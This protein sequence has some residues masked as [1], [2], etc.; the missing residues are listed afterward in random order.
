MSHLLSR[1]LVGVS[2]IEEN[3]ESRELQSFK[4]LHARETDQPDKVQSA[5]TIAAVLVPVVLVILVI[6]GI[7]IF[8]VIR[9][10]LPSKTPARGHYSRASTAS[11]DPYLNAPRGRID[12]AQ[13]GYRYD[14]ESAYELPPREERNPIYREILRVNTSD[15]LLA[16]PRQSIV[17]QSATSPPPFVSYP[18]KQDSL[19]D[20]ASQS[21]AELLVEKTPV[22][23]VN[24]YGLPG[25]PVWSSIWPS[26]W[27]GQK[28]APSAQDGDSDDGSDESFISGKEKGQLHDVPAADEFGSPG[29][30]SSPVPPRPNRSLHSDDEED[31]EAL[32]LELTRLIEDTKPTKASTKSYFSLPFGLSRSGTKRLNNVLD[33]QYQAPSQVSSLRRSAHFGFGSSTTPPD[34]VGGAELSPAGGNTLSSLIRRLAAPFSHTDRSRRMDYERA[35]PEEEV[36]RIEETEA[37]TM[38]PEHVPLDRMLEQ[39]A[40]PPVPLAPPMALH[41]VA[42]SPRTQPLPASTL[43]FPEP[44]VSPRLTLS[45]LPPSSTQPAS[46]LNGSKHVRSV[47]GGSTTTIRPPPVLPGS[48]Q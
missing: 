39:P 12:W 18:D 28:R 11:T 20:Y 29:V 37:F 6:S 32:E 42:L 33:R 22:E 41:S 47:S 24:S 30:P 23:K 9:R 43:S 14:P 7:A 34:Q 2:V 16:A 26:G 1:A 46:R 19:P 45:G 36:S 44:R 31:I 48:R 40:S 13:R 35:T 10:R 4:S 27:T 21:Q 15:T 25:L 38:S 8:V 3:L 17:M 5:R